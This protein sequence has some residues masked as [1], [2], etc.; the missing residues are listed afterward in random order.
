MTFWDG[1]GALHT[2]QEF[3]ARHAIAG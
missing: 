2:L 3:L 1:D